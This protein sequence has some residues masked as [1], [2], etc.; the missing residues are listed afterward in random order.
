[1]K[2]YSGRT[3]TLSHKLGDSWKENLNAGEDCIQQRV[4]FEVQWT[5][6]PVEIEQEVKNLW[7]RADFGNDYYYYSWNG[8]DEA[9]EYP[10]IHEYLSS[11]NI[12]ECLIHWW[13]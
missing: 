9:E 11:R 5:N 2:K 3:T 10:A 4:V 12:N 8:D 13:W 6:C 7:I 1:M